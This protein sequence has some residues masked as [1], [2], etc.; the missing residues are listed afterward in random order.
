MKLLEELAAAARARPAAR[1]VARADHRAPSLVHALGEPG[2]VAE[3]KPASPTQGAMRADAAA[4][5][6]AFLDAGACALSALT[7]PTRFGGSPDVLAAAVRAGGPVLMK[8]FVVTERQ[9]DL[10]E[11]AGAS[12]VL[13]I[14]PLLTRERSEWSRPEEAVHSAHAR[15][16][17]VVL[18][19]YDAAGLRRAAETAADLLAV[20]N[21]DLR[22]DALPVDADRFARVM[23]ELGPERPDAPVLALSGVET[24]DDVR[25]QLRAGACGVLVGTSLMKAADP[26]ARLAELLEGLA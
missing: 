22:D 18:E 9:L 7:E 1:D 20:N 6:A 11:R 2:L 12:A 5:A 13:L 14:L 10:A 17:E 15:G 26:A 21:R 16:L 23:R 25:R 4:L 8:D 24:A 19:A 3:L